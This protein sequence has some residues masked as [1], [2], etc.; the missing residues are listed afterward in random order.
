MVSLA[1]SLPIFAL[2]LLITNPAGA[3]HAALPD[4]LVSLDSEAGERLL[5]ESTARRDF[6]SLIEQYVTQEDPGYCGIASAVMVLNALQIPA[7][8]HNVWGA[9]FFTQ[10]NIF[11]D[12]AKTVAQPGFKGGLTLQQLADV[13]QSHPATAEVHYASDTTT[14]AFRTLAS[15]NMASPGD[16][17][18]VNYNRSEVGQE[19]MG[20]VS[21]IA[22]YHAGSDRFL[23]LDVARY[24]YP[25]VWVPTDRLF[26]AMATSDPVAGKSRG[27]LVVKGA[28]AAPGPSG[29]KPRSPI[30][31]LIGIVVAAFLLGAL[32]GGS[33][34][35]VRYRRALRRVASSSR[36]A[37]SAV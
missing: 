36:A 21:P 22:A 28:A 12:K 19:Y 15:S 34:Q 24:K 33:V 23:L 32:V 6:F 13:I 20:H 26:R 37:E 1:R 14:E 7:P 4:S 18:V 30:R 25:P 11:N 9:P 5:A 17:V 3:Q 2:A 29:I 35:T 10:A 31:I 16:F 8:E 27:F